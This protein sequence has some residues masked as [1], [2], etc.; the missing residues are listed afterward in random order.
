[1][2]LEARCRFSI[3]ASSNRLAPAGEHESGGPVSK[4]LLRQVL[5]RYVPDALSNV[6]GRFN[7]PSAPGSPARSGLGGRCLRDGAPRE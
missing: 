3:T 2:A 1:V 6:E 7:S 5:R 4:W